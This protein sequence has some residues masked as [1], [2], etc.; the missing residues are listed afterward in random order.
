MYLAWRRPTRVETFCFNKHQNY[1]VDIQLAAKWHYRKCI[2][3]PQLYEKEW[4]YEMSEQYDETK[5]FF[6]WWRVELSLFGKVWS[7]FILWVM[8]DATMGCCFVICTHLTYKNK[9]R[10]F[11]IRCRTRN[12]VKCKKDVNNFNRNFI[13]T[14]TAKFDIVCTVHR[15][16]LYKQ[17]NTMHFLYVF[18]LQFSYNSTCFERPFRSSSGVHDLLYL[19]LSTNHANVSRQVCMVCT[20][21]QNTVNHE[22]L[23]MKEMV[24]RNM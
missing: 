7:Y 20:D 2:H 19:Q 15:N 24:V 6:V 3:S 23:M 16:Q 10:P 18:I 11:N 22:L 5:F 12:A 8:C 17:T 1:C 14:S 9:P 13:A 21:L 4:P